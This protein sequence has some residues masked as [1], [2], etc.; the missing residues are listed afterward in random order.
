M[1][2]LIRLVERYVKIPAVS[3]AERPLREQILTDLS[4]C[5]D[6][7]VDPLGNILAVK[8][9]A[10]AAKVS[11]LLDA[12]MDEVGLIVTGVTERGFVRF[13]KVGGIDDRVLFG[14]RVRIGEVIGVLGG[15]PV[16]LLDEQARKKVHKADDL[17][18]DI[19]AKDRQDAL[20]YVKPGDTA[21]FDTDF[22]HLGGQIAARALDDRVG[23]A[24]LV[25]LLRSEIP[26]DLQV[27]FT[28]QEEVGCRGAAAAAFTVA[29]QAA[30]A[31]EA[32]TAADIHGVPEE[33][34]VCSLGGG[35]VVSFMDGGTVYD[36]AYYQ[37]ALELAGQRGIAAQPKQAVAGGNNAGAI[38]KSR[39]GVRT[40]ALSLPCRYIHSGLCVADQRDIQSLYD[41]TTAVAGQI[42]SGAWA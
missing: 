34:R 26:Y 23:C 18:I 42:A 5:C 14:R 24:V 6:C 37:A 22:L 8:K 1:T 9:G 17:L 39:G 25:Q 38:H 4:G 27:S 20:Q 32:T 30:I 41:L 7:R 11:V 28:V 33:Q 10:S 31:V 2:E 3:G 40:L 19:G 36:R 13:A 12:H 15:T 21:V 35:A 16:H 29:P